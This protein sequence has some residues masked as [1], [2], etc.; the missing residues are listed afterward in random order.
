MTT[1]PHVLVVEDEPS[2]ARL[3]QVQFQAA[4]FDV[5]CVSTGEEALTVAAHPAGDGGGFAAIVLDIALAGALDGIAVCQSLRARDDWTPVVFATA[6]DDEV[7][8]I[9][10]LELGADD[11]VTKPYSPREVVARVRAQ[12]RRDTLRR[13]P[14]SA[15]TLGWGALALDLDAHTATVAGRPV[16][17]TR[18]EFDLLAYVLSHA[19]RVCTRSE[20]LA[21]VWGYPPDDATRTV[22]THVAQLRAKLGEQC[23]IRTVR[24]LGYGTR[25]AP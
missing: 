18:T 22:D 2:I 21:Q 11:Y 3:L 7:D 25:P 14:A 16:A 1:A 9:V 13:A 15:P 24:G 10:G 20:L 4:G 5:T 6:R 12:I 23:P 19:R 8:R 17:L